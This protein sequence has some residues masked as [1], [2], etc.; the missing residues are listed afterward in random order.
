MFSSKYKFDA[1]SGFASFAKPID[2]NAIIEFPDVFDEDLNL[3]A[4]S[5]VGKAH[6]G[7]VFTDSAN[8]KIYRI[9]SAALRFIPKDKIY[10]E[11]YGYLLE[12]KDTLN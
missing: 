7:H 5:R 12:Q 3:E 2:P 8:K 9:N 11:G 10:D 6:L 1:G 4:S